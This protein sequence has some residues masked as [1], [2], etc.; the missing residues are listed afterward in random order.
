MTNE[1]FKTLRN[2]RIEDLIFQ[3]QRHDNTIANIVK[4][5]YER[6]YADGKT[7]KAL[8]NEQIITFGDLRPYFLYWNDHII[9]E[10][11]FCN[12]MM[13]ECQVI[14]VS[15]HWDNFEVLG[16]TSTLHCAI[17]IKLNYLIKETDNATD[18]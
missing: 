8:S 10:D 18:N 11:K 7:S 15:P 9:F 17:V 12:Q 16:L 3:I 13:E 4:S 14:N 6:G 1:D 2:S 5:A